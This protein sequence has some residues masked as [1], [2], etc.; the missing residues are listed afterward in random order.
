[1]LK[2]RPRNAHADRPRESVPRHNAL[3]YRV[4]PRRQTRSPHERVSPGRSIPCVAWEGEL[5]VL[6]EM[7][8]AVC[9]FTYARIGIRPVTSTEHCT[10]ARLTA[11]RMS[12]SCTGCRDVRHTA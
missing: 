1:M 10:Q 8:R 11:H 9:D 6:R 12:G 4:R 5:V 2:G 3:L 7:G